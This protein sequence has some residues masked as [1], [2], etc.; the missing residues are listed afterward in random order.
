MKRKSEG[1]SWPSARGTRRLSVCS[2]PPR[3]VL[4]AFAAAH[5]L[6]EQDTSSSRPKTGWSSSGPHFGLSGW[7][8]IV[9]WEPCP[10]TTGIPSTRIFRPGLL[11]PQQRRRSCP[12]RRRR[13]GVRT[14]P[15]VP[16]PPR[17]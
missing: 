3:G 16:A 8:F 12:N 11:P 1:T 4:L 9:T 7:R 13:G 17:L 5:R 14:T 2:R 15:P 6:L 10:T